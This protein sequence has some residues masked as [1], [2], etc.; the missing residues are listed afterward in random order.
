[1]GEPEFRQLPVDADEGFPQS[2]LLAMLGN[3]YR[4]ELYVN[5]AEEQLPTYPA[6]ADPRTAL[7]LIGDRRGPRGLL[8]LAVVRQDP[9]GETSLI[10]R[11]VLPGQVYAARELRLRFAE[12]TVA[13]GN[14]NGVGEF[15]S[16]IRAEVAAA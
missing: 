13:I 9:G 4:F 10:R 15:G 14:L 8:V 5:V 7:D 6:A 11:R 2:F 16:R 12:I 3:V 1:M